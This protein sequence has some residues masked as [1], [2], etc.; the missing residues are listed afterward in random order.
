MWMSAIQTLVKTMLHARM[1]LMAT[2]ANVFLD[3]QVIIIM[4]IIVMD[5]DVQLWKQIFNMDSIGL[6][7]YKLMGILHLSGLSK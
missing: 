3:I 4:V 6:L 2:S 1:W 7:I 5:F